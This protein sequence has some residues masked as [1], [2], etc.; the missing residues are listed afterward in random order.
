[1]FKGS[2]LRNWAGFVLGILFLVMTL[3]FDP[4]QGMTVD[5]WK[6]VGMGTLM[7]VWW[8]SEAAPI[9]I[10]SLMPLVLIPLLNLGTIRSAAAPYASPTIYL[11]LGGFMLGLAMEKWNLHKR[12]ALYILRIMGGKPS[13]QIGGF[14]IATG[15]ISMWMSNTATAIMMLPIGLSVIQMITGGREG[16]E[17]KRYANALLLGIAYAAG[18]GGIGTII[19]TP[20]NALLV[21][22]LQE[23]YG[24]HVGFG[25]WMLIGVPVSLVLLL[26]T[27]V[28]LTYRP[29]HFK[30]IDMHV[31]LEK[32]IRELGPI[33]RAE[34]LVSIIFFLAA[35]SWVCQPLIARFIPAVSDTV[36]AMIFGLLLFLVP[37]DSNR[38]EFLMDWQQASKIPWGVLL[39]FGGGLSLA[40]VISKSGLAEWFVASMRLLDVLPN[41][42]VIFIIV[43]MTIIMTEFTSNTAT[44]ATFLPLVGSL[45]ISQGLAPEVFAV[46]A[47]VA[48]SCAFML[49]V[50][51]PPNAMVFASGKLSIG[52]MI[53]IGCVLSLFCAVVVPL[54]C[55]PL[56]KLVW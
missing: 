16:V 20:P 26:A 23:H 51:T 45:A 19:G 21:A 37:L 54:L 40:S 55:F 36:I 2:T 30:S 47:A 38:E 42:F 33:S 17:E 52:T 29:F 6:C 49:P 56:V 11:F 34:M 18:L 7:A 4:P 1:M 14:M 44:A 32:E 48:A 39:L 24:I 53:R 15:F 8:A 43:F 35:V 13:M 46:P 50:S 5:A 28:R 3:V 41:L 25:Q 31:F 27:W 12:I 9:P 10:T 22:F